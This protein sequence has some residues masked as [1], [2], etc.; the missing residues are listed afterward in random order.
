[1]RREKLI[2]V[3]SLSLKNIYASIV[4]ILIILASITG[5]T[6]AWFAAQVAVPE[7]TFVAGTV[8]LS[9]PV[10]EVEEL[11]SQ[12]RFVKHGFVPNSGEASV[13]KVDLTTY[14]EVAR[15][16]TAPRLYDYY[17]ESPG[18]WVYND[19]VD[20]YVWRTSRIAQDAD[21]NAWVLNTG[22][23][24]T[25]LQGSAVRIQAD[26]DGLSTTANTATP[27][28]FGTDQAVQ[29]FEVG[30]P[31]D[32]PRAIAID[33]NGYIW[34]G[35]YNT[36]E[37]YK[38]VYD[39]ITGILST[40]AGP[41]KPSSSER[42]AYYEMK[43]APN[44]MFFISSRDAGSMGIWSFNGTSF[45]RE[46]TW[47][48]YSILIA[49]DNTVYATA[50]SSQIWIRDG[51]TSPAT[52]SSKTITGSSQNRGMAF[53]GLGNIWIASTVN[54]SSG[55]TIYSYNIASESAGDTYSL[56]SGTT[57]V[58]IGKDPAGNMWAVCR[59][60]NNTLGGYIEGFAP[61]TLVK[62]GA[63]Q[64]GFRPYAYGDFT[65]IDDSCKTV[66]WSFE[67][68]GT[69]KVYVR[70]KPTANLNG[71]TVEITL[72]EQETNWLLGSDG[73]YYYGN[74]GDEPG[75]TIVPV[76]DTNNPVSNVVN[77]CFKYCFAAETGNELIVKLEAEAIQWSNDA[78]D[79]EWVVWVDNQV[80]SSHPW[81]VGPN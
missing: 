67:N 78:I 62:V 55:T 9:T 80:V 56:T 53:D 69:K 68:V 10:I 38:Y 3:K 63:I 28:I 34:I 49:D 20:P 37:L 25:N 27:L 17:E 71:N 41:F 13:S 79:H 72:C 66:K 43:I 47:N 54:T 35:F 22:R 51:S 32:I 5:A 18:S 75:P 48:P 77:V 52:W 70:V 65:L 36:G 44:G 24:G 14:Q 39:E 19:D 60:D 46:T 50:Y 57:P 29:V 61:E 42:I 33:A 31:G 7:T 6:Y 12:G 74:Y 16:Y 11:I 2:N 73:W 8:R 1:M 21:G 26:T 58:G 76:P 81:Y 59:T 64:V 30:E 45:T 23:D 40:V 4:V 15:Y